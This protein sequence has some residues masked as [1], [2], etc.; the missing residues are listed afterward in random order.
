MIDKCQ[1]KL[2]P[3]HY[4]AAI[5]SPANRH[6]LFFERSKGGNFSYAEAVRKRQEGINFI[7]D[8][9]DDIIANAEDEDDNQ[10]QENDELNRAPSQKRTRMLNLLCNFDDDNHRNHRNVRHGQQENQ[11]E[12]NQLNYYLNKLTFTAQQKRDC[13]DNPLVF[14]N[15]GMI[16]RKT[17]DFRKAG[18]SILVVQAGSCPSERIFSSMK[19]LSHQNDHL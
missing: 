17:P 7:Q 11:I 16:R 3:I 10:S 6:T 15:S 18:L 14:L 8:R 19:I 12:S 13:F 1:S 5:L 9:I 4:A 2:K